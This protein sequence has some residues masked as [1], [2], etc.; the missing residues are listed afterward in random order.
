MKS[1]RLQDVMLVPLKAEVEYETSRVVVFTS[2]RNSI[3]FRYFEVGLTKRELL[4]LRIQNVTTGVTFNRQRAS[5][6][7]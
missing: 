2:I 1:K 7:T 4:D 6:S 3:G 5:P